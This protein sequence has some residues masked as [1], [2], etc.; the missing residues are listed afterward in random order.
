MDVF[1]MMGFFKAFL[2]L[3]FIIVYIFLDIIVKGNVVM[4]GFF[5]FVYVD[6]IRVIG[7]DCYC[8][9]GVVKEI[10]GNIFLGLFV[11]FCFLDVIIGVFKVEQIGLFG[12][13]CYGVVLFVLEWFD[14]MLFQFIVKFRGEI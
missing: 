3:G 13:F 4:Y 7:I 5:F 14:I 11:I 10:I 12:Y 2:F 9:N 1:Y 8:I 6:Y